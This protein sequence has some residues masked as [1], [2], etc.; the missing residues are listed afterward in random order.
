ME[1]LMSKLPEKVFTVDFIPQEGGNIAQIE[2]GHINNKKANGNMNTAPV[3]SSSGFWQVDNISFTIGDPGTGHLIPINSSMIF[4]PSRLYTCRTINLAFSITRILSNGSNDCRYGRIHSNQRRSA[5][6]RLLLQ[7]RT[8]IRTRQRLRYQLQLPVQRHT[9][10]P[11]LEH[12]ERHSYLSFFAL[13]YLYS[14]LSNQQ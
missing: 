8:R 2:F 6:P 10:R 1:K 12:R 4:G 9:S 3:N 11:H 5:N 13:E 7:L 14:R